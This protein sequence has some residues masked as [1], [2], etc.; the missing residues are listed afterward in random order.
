MTAQQVVGEVLLR[1]RRRAARTIRRAGDS[2][3]STYITDEELRRALRGRS[4]QEV[5]QQLRARQS[6]QLTAGLADLPRTSATIKQLFPETLDHTCHEADAILAH[7]IKVFDHAYDY[8]AQID[9]HMD[10][11]ARVRWPLAHFTRVPL[12]LGRGAD[13][14]QVWELNRLAHLAVLGRAYALTGDER[15]TEELLIQLASWY[16]A[17]P[18]RF[19]VNWSIA[20]EVALRAVNL[21]AAFQLAL[22]SSHLT[23]DAVELMLKLMLAHG[24]FIRANLEYSHRTLSNHYLSDLLGLYVIGTTVPCL[25]ESRNW[26][27]FSAARLLKELAR[28]VYPDGVDYEGSIAYHRFVLEIFALFF[29]L[30]TANGDEFPAGCRER[31]EAMFGFV[32][33]YLKPD[34]RAPMIGDSD[35][36]RPLCFTPRAAD[37]HAYLMS[38]AAIML[39]DAKFKLSNQPD[40]EALWWFGNAGLATF[41]S[42]SLNN[43]AP[44]SEAFRDAQIYVQRADDVYAIIDCGDHGLKGRGSH[45]HSDALSLELFAYGATFLRDPGTFTYTASRR[46]RNLFRSTA[47]HN[48][49]R[50]DGQEI[51]PFNESELFAFRANV[52][53]RVNHWQS[54][55]EQDLLDA[56]HHSYTRLPQPITH[57]RVITFNK[58]DRFW[59]IKDSFT[60]A[61]THLF[62]YFFNFDVG[63]EVSLTE[64]KGLVAKGERAALAIIPTSQHLFTIKRT[65]RWV[66]PSYGTRHRASGII[67]RQRTSVPF[68]SNI[69]FIPYRIGEDERVKRIQE[70]G[71]RKK[72]EGA[73]AP[74]SFSLLSSDS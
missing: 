6:P 14:R 10:P 67:F 3:D 43:A 19:G 46:W 52:C 16:E 21:I 64:Q 32:R 40:E 29:A 68:E 44:T 62:E 66:S 38:I 28:Q 25:Q 48:T 8:D 72:A 61:G 65:S 71:V 34:G 69:L 11:R 49:V 13:V 59:T 58:Q 55:D 37:Q 42:L 12:K 47:Y 60:G 27:R 17:N 2:P 51:S 73:L 74:T 56:E 18:P 15:Y 26:A 31:L 39:N 4:L 24:R 20:M 36:G 30:R 33:A 22:A 63:I 53:P 57:R 23:D 7:R 54:D 5:A 50:I 45:A 1:A 35:D 70:S 9:W 41:D